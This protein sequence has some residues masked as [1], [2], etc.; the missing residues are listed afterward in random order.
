M[1]SL[2][3]GNY[4]VKQKLIGSNLAGAFGESI[5]INSD[6]TLLMMR[7]YRDNTVSALVYTG[8]AVGGW[9]FKQELLGNTIIES[10]FRPGQNVATNSAG[11]VLMMGEPNDDTNGEKAGSVLVYTGNSIDGWAL[12]QE[13]TGESAG[14]TFGQS[15][16]TNSAGTVLMMGGPSGPGPGATLV[17]TGNSDAGWGLKQKITGDSPSDYLGYSVATNSAGTVLIMGVPFDDAGGG[18]L[19]GAALIYVGNAIAGW[20]FKQKL[21]GDSPRDQF[22]TS[23]AINSAGTVLI[24]GAPDDNAGGTYAGAALVYTGNSV[25]GWGLKQK[26]VGITPSYGFG[27]SVAINSGGTLLIM[28]GPV[29]DDG[30]LGDGGALVYTGDS[31]AGWQLKQRLTGDSESV[32]I[33]DGFGWGVATNND[34][35]VLMMGGF[36]D[37][38]GGAGAGASLIYTISGSSSSSSSSI[39]TCLNAKLYSN[40]NFGWSIDINRSGSGILIGAPKTNITEVYEKKNVGTAW[41]YVRNNDTWRKFPYKSPN[42]IQN[43]EFGKSVS[44]TDGNFLAIGEPYYSNND[45]TETP[46]DYGFGAVHLYSFDNTPLPITTLTGDG[47]KLSQF[48]YSVD[49]NNRGDLLVVGAPTAVN[50]NNNRT[51]GKVYLYQNINNNWE[52]RRILTGTNNLGYF[53][54]CVKINSG[55]VI[56]IAEHT[57]ADIYTYNITNNTLTRRHSFPLEYNNFQTTYN[58]NF[59]EF[60]DIDINGNNILIGNPYQSTGVAQLYRRASANVWL[61]TGSFTGASGFQFFGASVALDDQSNI[62]IGAPKENVVYFYSGTNNQLIEK[63]GYNNCESFSGLGNSIAADKYSKTTAIGAYLTTVDNKYAYQDG[64]VFLR[65]D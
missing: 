57:E 31:V 36:A 2:L 10:F 62:Y 43:G 11:T 65:E 19:A 25:N 15:V 23:V 16:A 63:I 46:F 56:V 48:G 61:N 59:N 58:Y 18:I 7:G 21:V 44:V 37:D 20:Q 34:G 41:Y 39:N 52:L 32:D 28:G 49:L 17:Y 4:L 24:I 27:R 8:S 3:T 33:G 42:S 40:S 51:G 5:A 6:G 29:D 30:G 14:D 35:T 12:K 54:K 1:S 45:F 55:N 13:L 64:A 47:Q 50:T 9:Q 22:G 60:I 38:E 53:G 26:L